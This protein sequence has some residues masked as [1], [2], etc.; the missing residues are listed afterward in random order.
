MF[1]HL[2]VTVTIALLAAATPIVVKDNLIRLPMVKRFNATS[3]QTLLQHDQARARS[4]KTGR[5]AVPKTTSTVAAAAAAAS[6]T[7]FPEAI[8]NTAVAYTAEVLRHF[9]LYLS[10]VD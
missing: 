6:G 5:L 8:T 2:T 7:S 4:L 10:R 1:A 3:T 9:H